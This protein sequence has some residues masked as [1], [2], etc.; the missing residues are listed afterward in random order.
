MQRWTYCCLQWNSQGQKSHIKQS[1]DVDLTSFSI[2][3]CKVL[4]I[5]FSEVP[6]SFFVWLSCF[7]FTAAQSMLH[8]IHFQH[9]VRLHTFSDWLW[10]CFTESGGQGSKSASC[11]PL[12]YTSHSLLHRHKMLPP[13]INW[14]GLVW[15]SVITKICLFVC[16]FHTFWL[17]EAELY[18]GQIWRPWG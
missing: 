9:S 1:E 4:P 13:I 8:A 7:L 15:V 3:E 18:P 11:F 12:C 5:Y 10:W 2:P 14:H 16:L 17:P 6:S